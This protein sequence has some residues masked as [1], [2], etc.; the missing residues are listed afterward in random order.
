MKKKFRLWLCRKWRWFRRRS[1]YV[2]LDPADSSVTLS[3]ALFDDMDVMNQEQAKV[4]VCRLTNRT[5]GNDD[6]LYGFTLNPNIKKPTQLCDIQYNSKY[7]CIG[8]ETLCPTVNR[9]LYDYALPTA[10]VKLSVEPET[11]HGVNYYAI[12]RP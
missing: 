6:Y 10:K 7:R 4:F 3:Q 9:I 5:A 1:M 8:F 12:L 11:R 2:I